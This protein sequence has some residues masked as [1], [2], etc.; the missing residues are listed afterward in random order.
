M[1]ARKIAYDRI[2]PALPLLAVGSAGSIREVPSIKPFVII[3][4]GVLTTRIKHVAVTQPVLIYVHD[5]PGSYA[6]IDATLNTIRDAMVADPSA[7][8]VGLAGITWINRSADLADDYYSTVMRYDTYLI[9]GK[10]MAA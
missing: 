2:A 10:E 8:E 4:L 1:D 6:R 7:S 3:T 5:E 9:N